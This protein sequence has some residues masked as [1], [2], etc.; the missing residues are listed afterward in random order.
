MKTR[1]RTS[2]IPFLEKSTPEEYDLVILGGGTGS[3]PALRDTILA[4]P[5]L[6]EGPIPLFS[7][8]PSLPR[9]SKSAPAAQGAP[10]GH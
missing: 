2:S 8:T 10:S 9:F 7:S 3:T 1:E 6:V 4:H 5:T